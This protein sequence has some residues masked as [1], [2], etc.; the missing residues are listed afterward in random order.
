MIQSM[1]H[2]RKHLIAEVAA[3]FSKETVEALGRSFRY[4]CCNI[5]I[6]DLAAYNTPLKK[7]IS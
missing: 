5:M 7:S 4:L 3:A 6:R 1:M 2:D